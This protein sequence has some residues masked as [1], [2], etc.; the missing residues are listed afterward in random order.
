VACASAWTRSRIGCAGYEGPVAVSQRVCPS[1]GAVSRGGSSYC[2]HCGNRLTDADAPTLVQEPP[3]E[4]RGP[5]QAPPPSASSSN[6]L[7]WIAT[8]VVVIL[9]AGGGATAIVLGS[10]KSRSTP[11][12]ASVRSPSTNSSTVPSNSNSTGAATTSTTTS[13]TST[14]SNGGSGRSGPLEVL[15]NYWGSISN[16]DFTSAYGRLAPGAVSQTEAQFVSQEQQ[17]GIQSVS[18]KGHVSS[19]NGSTATVSVD[20]LTTKDTQF[21]CRTWSGSYQLVQQ[22]GRW[23]IEQASITPTPCGG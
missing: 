14:A 13:T 21:G 23:L 17:A 20:S 7:V 3:D 10:Q 19:Q 1:C 4:G 22:G 16:H 15:K 11:A 9:L 8:A 5:A 2:T 18:F 6:R 12:R